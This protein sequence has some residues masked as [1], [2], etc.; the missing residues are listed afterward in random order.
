MR[1]ITIDIY[2]NEA[3]FYHLIIEGGSIENV[4]EEHLTVHGI[5]SIVKAVISEAIETF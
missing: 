3:G 2:E 4:D 5:Q 1:R